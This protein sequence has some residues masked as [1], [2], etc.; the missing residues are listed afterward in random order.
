MLNVNHDIEDCDN[1][2]C[3]GCDHKYG[4]EIENCEGNHDTSDHD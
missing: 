2:Y 4:D 1:D 3:D